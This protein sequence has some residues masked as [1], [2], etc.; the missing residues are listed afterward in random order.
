MSNSPFVPLAITTYCPPVV[1]S[2]IQRPRLISALNSSNA[3]LVVIKAPTGCGKTTLA[4]DWSIELVSRG[5]NVAWIRAKYDHNND[6]RAFLYYLVRAVEASCPEAAEVAQE[7]LQQRGPASAYAVVSALA[8]GITESGDDLYLFIDD[9]H[10]FEL[11][12]VHET[13]LFLYHHTPNHFRLVLISREEPDLPMAF[14]RASAELFMLGAYQLRFS[15]SEAEAFFA[16]ESA[17]DLPM[18]FINSFHHESRGWAA[19]L[20]IASVSLRSG[21]SAENILR[22]L[23]SGTRDIDAFLEHAFDRLPHALLDFLEK[24]SILRM[25]SPEICNNVASVDNADEILE[26]LYSKYQLIQSER[27]P[28]TLYSFHPLIGKYLEQRLQKRST[29]QYIQTLHRRAAIWLDAHGEHVAAVKHAINADE[30]ALAAQWV[31][32]FA[33]RMIRNGDIRELLGCIRWLPKALT[34]RHFPLRLA[35]GWSLALAP[36]RSQVFDWID[37]IEADTVGQPHELYTLEECRAIRTVALG[38]S[39]EPE[40]AFQSGLAHM[41]SPNLNSWVK[42]AVRNALGYCYLIAG[43]HALIDKT[44]SEST[45]VDGEL[46]FPPSE[47]YKLSITGLSMIQR[48]DFN[49]ARACFSQASAIAKKNLRPTSSLAVTP[50]VFMA[51]LAYEGNHIAVAERLIGDRLHLTNAAGFL[52]VPLTAYQT[53]I[54][55]AMLKKDYARAEELLDQGEAIALEERWPRMHAALLVERIKLGIKKDD[56]W[57]LSNALATLDWVSRKT[58]AQ[59]QAIQDNLRASLAIGIAYVRM[60]EYDFAAAAEALE[61]VWRTA[62]M[63]SNR[64]FA[65]TVG[66]LFSAADFQCGQRSRASQR[67]LRVLGY[68]SKGQL[69]RT[70]VDC[71]KAVVPL[72]AS[73]RERLQANAGNDRQTAYLA[74]IFALMDGTY[75]LGQPPSALMHNP[76]SRRETEVLQIIA[77]GASNKRIAA[78][79][80]VSPETVK[81]FIKSIFIKLKVDNRVRAVTEARRQKILNDGK[82]STDATPRAV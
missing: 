45:G 44:P 20:R 26:T 16:L 5:Q 29:I 6:P 58:P 11:R 21:I 10:W 59:E 4:V 74:Q 9:Y 52:E 71:G 30:H 57:A 32:R 19:A 22:A 68:A 78:T 75:E 15:L 1:R 72:L 14:L 13:L 61:P 80:G 49:E 47:I 28:K 73:A 48:L 79:L 60:Y 43:R 12:E 76:L 27:H 23:R 51:L 41:E 65:C 38:L 55:V 3:R 50:T 81:S 8:N 36:L 39:D 37:E 46:S 62:D 34:H 40:K 24:S 42:S 56:S 77:T 25:L 17:N 64:Y 69:L 35:I 53:M 70:I 66:T 2:R 18:G 31:E 82:R 54:R 67:F 33:M 63:S 7:M